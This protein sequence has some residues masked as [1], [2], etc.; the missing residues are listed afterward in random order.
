MQ[1]IDEETQKLLD[2]YNIKTLPDNPNY[3]LIRTE[4]GSF[5]DIFK[6]KNY[7]SLGFD[8][9][10]INDI[11][12][13]PDKENDALLKEKIAMLYPEN[14]M[15]GLVLGQLR[16]FLYSIEKGDI[17]IIPSK[18]SNKLC[19]GQAISDPYQIEKE[20]KSREVL[21]DTL[22]YMKRIDVKWIAEIDKSSYDVYIYRLLS[23]HQ[24]IVNAEQYK[25]F[26]NRMIFPMYYQNGK[27]HLCFDIKTEDNISLDTTFD[28]YSL[29]KESIE[30]FNSLTDSNIQGDISVKST[31]NS[32]GLIEFLG[33]P[34]IM[35]AVI[36]VLF[37][38]GLCGGKVN[39]THGVFNM[40][41]EGDG[42]LKKILD[43]YSEHKQKKLDDKNLQLET[44]KEKN[45]EKIAE[46]NQI[47]EAYKEQNSKDTE[48][49]KIKLERYKVKSQETLE[50]LKA[51]INTNRE[52]EDDII[53]IQKENKKPSKT[54]KED[55]NQQS[56]FDD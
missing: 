2:L 56:F 41:L 55:P 28:F 23:S 33:H 45:R 53:I 31:V 18:N 6:K 4:S 42:L 35:I 5:Y 9:I 21:T 22:T 36:T 43:L 27:I 30:L 39:I 16:K 54:K 44:L 19:I 29:I 15:P 34:T 24:A 40:N 10:D 50:K 49:K 13:K 47:L 51:G 25:S 8:K 48:D 20:L 32:P 17:I 1:N 37:I 52:I 14:Q 11:P 7:V 38:V 12:E 46:R 26:I 3:W